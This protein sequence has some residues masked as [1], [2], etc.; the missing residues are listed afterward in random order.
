MKF[1]RIHDHIFSLLK[2]AS[3]FI[4][5]TLCGC[6]SNSGVV[7]VAKDTFMVTRQ[8]ATGFSGSGN[9]K[10]EALR[11]AAAYCAS[12]GKEMKLVAVTESAPPY[13]LGNFPKAEVIFK[14]LPHD[15]PELSRDA[16]FDPKGIQVK[17]V[18][19]SD[20]VKKV[21]VK[22]SVTNAIDVYERLEKLGELRG[23]GVITEEEF[24]IQKKRI[25]DNAN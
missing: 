14:A 8:A 3:V 6:A 24:I 20:E 4:I 13:V 23:K 25:L 18:E 9:L 5:L 17:V 21:E 10:A 2:R 16:Y 11:E 1:D 7:A 19:R 12:Q 22:S 15:S